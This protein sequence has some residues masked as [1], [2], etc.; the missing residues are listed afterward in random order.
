MNNNGTQYKNVIVLSSDN[1]TPINSIKNVN[2]I[3]YDEEQGIIGFDDL[4]NKH[5]RLEI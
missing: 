4:N 2:V 1:K 3:Y 5:W